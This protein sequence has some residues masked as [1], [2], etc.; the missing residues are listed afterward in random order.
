VNAFLALIV[1][2]VVPVLTATSRTWFFSAPKGIPV[3]AALSGAA[4]LALGAVM[5]FIPGN[6]GG[7][8]LAATP[9]MQ[10]VV[11][12]ILIFFGRIGLGVFLCSHFGV[13]FPS[14]R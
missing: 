13:G 2:G 5:K 1:V 4:L 11:F 7:A 3:W 8:A 9:L 10:A 14:R 12:V 6:F